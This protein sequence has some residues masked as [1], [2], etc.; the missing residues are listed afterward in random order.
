ME[1]S[2]FSDQVL[3]EIFHP[4]SVK[5]IERNKN[6]VTISVCDYCEMSERV[7][8]VIDRSP[9]DAPCERHLPFDLQ[10]SRNVPLRHINPRRCERHDRKGLIAIC[11]SHRTTPRVHDVHNTHIHS[12]DRSF[13]LV[14][15]I[16]YIIYLSSGYTRRFERIY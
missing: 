5:I 16:G 7:S 14:T 4:L 3:V 13:H 1:T 2:E 15:R 11:K 8:Q 10:V 12:P 6:S 9:I